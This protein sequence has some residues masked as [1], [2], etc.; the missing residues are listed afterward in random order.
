MQSTTNPGDQGFISLLN[1]ILVTLFQFSGLSL[2]ENAPL[3]PSDSCEDPLAGMQ[4]RLL[5][6]YERTENVHTFSIQQ[7]AMQTR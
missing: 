4:G 6:L 2:K 1:L 5:I 7:P 3:T